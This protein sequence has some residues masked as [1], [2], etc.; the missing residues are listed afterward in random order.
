V[1]GWAIINEREAAPEPTPVS[2]ERAAL[3]GIVPA[4]AGR[5]SAAAIIDVIPAILFAT[6]L[7]FAV[8]ALLVGE[9][10]GILVSAICVVLLVVYGLIQ[11]TSNG[12]RGQ[13]F[14]KQMMR[15]RT[16][17]P[18]TLKPIGFGRALLRALI[19]ALAGIVPVV[20]PAVML[21]SP[22]WDAEQRRRGWHDHAAR[23]W[24]IDLDAVDP[25]DPVAFEAARGRARVR[26]VALGAA[27]AQPE[28]PAPAP[29]PEPAAPPAWAPPPVEGLAPP[30][31][32]AP[33]AP[34]ASA[35]APEPPRVA[36]P[37]PPAGQLRFDTG[38]IVAIHGPG[39]VG[40][41]PRAADDEL[42]MHLVP[43]ADDTR[44][45]SKTHFA[46]GI[47]AQGLFVSDRG[48]TNGTS[49]LRAGGVIAAPADAPVRL[50]AGDRIVFGDRFADV[51]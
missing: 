35:R 15:I 32:P 44:S 34:P 33:A 2:I 9:L 1:S 50:I 5:R 40:R 51:L 36:P 13:T 37:V 12:R 19:V 24:L 14:G 45:I 46:I 38:E 30:P 3:L 49:I 22:L 7:P 10:W 6:P 39:L 16:I 47:D 42:V 28:A 11:L 18:A 20:G 21:C 4:P 31:S 23:S 29:R 26:S 27:A 41:A 8:R 48:S 43:I 25:T 17:D